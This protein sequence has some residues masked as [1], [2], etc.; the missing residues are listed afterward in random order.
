[1]RF[2]SDIDNL[3]GLNDLRNLIVVEFETDDPKKDPVGVLQLVNK[4]GIEP[5]SKFD[6]VRLRSSFLGHDKCS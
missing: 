1:M 3:L 6:I 2:N 5:L 4:K